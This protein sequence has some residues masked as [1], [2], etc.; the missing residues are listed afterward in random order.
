MYPATTPLWAVDVC[1]GGLGDGTPV[2]WLSEWRLCGNYILPLL[3][4][5]I[6]VKSYIILPPSEGYCHSSWI[7]WPDASALE[8]RRGSQ[9]ERWD[10]FLHSCLLFPDTFCLVV[11]MVNEADRCRAVWSPGG[12]GAHALSKGAATI[13]PQA[14]PATVCQLTISWISHFSPIRNVSQ[15]RPLIKCFNFRML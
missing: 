4:P 9:E 3:P 10:V 12:Q 8:Q 5:G 14:S 6:N 15:T 1:P 11:M 2:Q 13:L 7:S